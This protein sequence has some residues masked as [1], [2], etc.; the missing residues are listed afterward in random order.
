MTTVPHPRRVPPGKSL[1]ERNPE[2][3]SQWS[4]RNELTPANYYSRSGEKVWWVCAQGHEWVATVGSRSRIGA[5]CPYCA[6][7]RAVPGETDLASV[8]P[9]LAAEWHPE[10][11]D[12][13]PSEVLPHA[14]LRVWWVCE[15][16]HEWCASVNSRSRGTGCPVCAGKQPLS[17]F[18]DLATTHPHLVAGWHPTRNDRNP[19]DVTKGSEHR[20]WWVC[21]KGH[22]WEA[23]ICNRVSGFQCPY[24]SGRRVLAGY[25][26]LL[27]HYPALAGECHPARNELG[28]AEVTFGSEIVLWWVCEKGHEWQSRVNNRVHGRGCPRC[29]SAGSSK[30]EYEINEFLESLGLTTQMHHRQI[31]DSYEYDVTVPEKKVAIEFNGLYWHSEKFKARNYHRDKT[32]AAEKAGWR[33]IHVWEDDWRDKPEVVKKMLA[34]KLG[35]SK[36]GRVN[37]RSLGVRDAPVAGSNALLEANH[38]QG[39]GRGSVRLGLYRGDELV[40]VALFLRRRSGEWELT[41]YGSSCIV[42]GGFS[43][44]L[45]AFVKNRE[46]DRL[47][48][49]SDTTVSDGGLYEQLGFVRDGVIAPDYQYVVN[50]TRE[51]KFNYRLKRFRDD[52]ELDHRDGLTEKQLAELNGLTRVY[53][54]GKVRW[55][56][57]H[58]AR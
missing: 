56:L 18:N 50:G 33:V 36:E 17:G 28:P 9:A 58:P 12:K 8:N 6:G 22:E 43:K 5:G 11:N 14:A 35:V 15:N 54:A 3:L 7:Q 23:T 51:H 1:A 29:A 2:L 10:K 21:Q 13:Q 42:R 44:L 27:T 24:C 4:D 46:F 52:P 30:P 47:V 49:F 32:L 26:D 53:D 31:A 19:Q 37:A 39:T 40:A 16:G 38:I 25:N 41:R 57:D 55:T 45:T 34:R 48:T 20:A